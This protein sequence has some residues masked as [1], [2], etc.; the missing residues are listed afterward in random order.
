MTS[1]KRKKKCIVCPF[2]KK[3]KKTSNWALLLI[4]FVLAF[5]FQHFLHFLNNES[6]MIV[7]QQHD[8]TI[9]RSHQLEGR[10]LIDF[11]FSWYWLPFSE[12]WPSCSPLVCV[13]MGLILALKASLFHEDWSIIH[14]NPAL[15]P[16][17]WAVGDKWTKT[18]PLPCCFRTHI[19]FI[20]YIFSDQLSLFVSP[21]QILAYTEGLHGKW[22]FTEIRAIFSRRYLLQNTA[23]EVFMANR[24]K[25]WSLAVL[26][27]L[28][29]L[30]KMYFLRRSLH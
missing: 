27:N 3:K 16:W 8:K 14:I 17:A 24:S 9:S 10:I 26:E 15:Q 22:Q 5:C 2:S 23:L 1:A 6:M 11:Q 21:G 12:L 19:P 13:W 30:I 4:I 25:L 20:F 7:Q 28:K 18:F 29:G